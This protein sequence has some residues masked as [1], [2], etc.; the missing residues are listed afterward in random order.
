MAAEQL[1]GIAAETTLPGYTQLGLDAL[2][3]VEPRLL[4]FDITPHPVD[5]SARLGRFA[6]RL[7]MGDGSMCQLLSY[8]AG[9][10]IGPAQLEQGLAAVHGNV[11]SARGHHFETFASQASVS[12]PP[13]QITKKIVMELYRVVDIMQHLQAGPLEIDRTVFAF[14]TGRPKVQAGGSCNPEVF[15]Q[16]SGAL[17]AMGFS[18]RHPTSKNTARFHTNLGRSE[19]FLRIALQ[20]PLSTS[21]DY[22]G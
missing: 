16:A 6:F 9:H 13:L 18:S 14:Q 8:V 15:Q 20:N 1:V 10:V 17:T 4:Q 5:A 12:Q 11:S 3:N 22:Y 21:D 2:Y 19:F 7:G